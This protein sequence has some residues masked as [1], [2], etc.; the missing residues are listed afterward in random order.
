MPSTNGHGAEPERVALYLRVSSLE[1]REAGTIETQEQYLEQYTAMRGLEVTGQY[2]DD[3]VPG[4]VAF[5]E[6]PEGARL[7]DDARAGHFDSVVCYKLDRVGRSLLNVIDAHDRLEAL[8]VGLR[9]AK[10][11]IETTTPAGRLQFQMLG[12]FAEF[13]RSSIRERTQDGL[14]RALRAGKQPGRLPYG[15]HIGDDG[16]FEVVED[17]ARIIAQIFRQVAEGSTIYREVKRLNDEGI[18][19]PG[20]RI[21]GKER[22][23]GKRLNTTAVS[24]MLASRT[25]IGKQEV[26]VKEGQEV[27][28]REV[29]AI[30]T[31]ALWEQVRRTLAQNRRTPVGRDGKRKGLRRYLLSGLIRCGVCGSPCTAHSVTN[32]DKRRQYYACSDSRSG[33]RP[34]RGPKGHARF[35]PA[36]WLEETVWA[37]IR[38]FLENPG[39][40]LERVRAELASA[41]DAEEL[42]ARHADLSKR[43]KTKHK[44]RDR[45]IRLCA[46]GYITEGELD[47]YLADLRTQ[48]DNLE[49]LLESVEAELARKRGEAELAASTEAWLVT[50]RERIHEVEGDSEEAFRARHHLVRLLV[51]GIV[52]ED[53]RKREAPRVRIT[54]RFDE[55]EDATDERGGEMCEVSQNTNEFLQAKAEAGR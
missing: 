50:L 25:Y 54:Y 21:S 10:E 24:D 19:A 52:I 26:K 53:K 42:E 20:Y 41:D 46:Q 33:E 13:E 36:G 34:R 8:G 15:Y 6:R 44:E 35:L 40:T 16:A 38:G 14:H 3:G 37:D 4:T 9:S 30:V 55:P 1:Q 23:P 47:G 2:A 43:I 7:L 12:G 18:P 49:M 27:I 32:A 48:A 51:E 45:Y 31:P 28:T 29:P 17:E 22:I 11:Q 5:H 39:E